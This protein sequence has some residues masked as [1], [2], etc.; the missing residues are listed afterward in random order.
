M[1]QVPV[2]EHTYSRLNILKAKAV[3][4]KYGKSATWAD[5]V[6][7]ACDVC[8]TCPEVFKKAVQIKKGKTRTVEPKN[9]DKILMA[10][11]KE[12]ESN[13]EIKEA[14]EQGDKVTSEDLER[15]NKEKRMQG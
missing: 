5:I 8:V 11:K 3:M 2:S 13:A 10:E 15:V 14:L 12:L 1:A 4:V 7:A 9:G 6:A